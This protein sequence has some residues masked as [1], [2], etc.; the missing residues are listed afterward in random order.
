MIAI[1]GSRGE[2]G[3]QILRSALALSLITGVPFTI[4][5]IRA[6]R[7]RP[8]LQPQHLMCV[9]AAT[10]LGQ[11]QAIG[12]ALD[13]QR[14]EF[15]P[16]A[17]VGGHYEFP[18]RTA[19][20]SSLVLQTVLPP[21]LMAGEPSHV[22]VTG[23]TYN[24][25]APP[26]DFL[27]QT[28]L[29]QIRQLGPQVTLTL[30]RPGFYPRGGGRVAAEIQ[31]ARR[32]ARFELVE[33]GELKACRVRALV[34][35][36]DRPIAKRECQTVEKLSGLSAASCEIVELSARFGPGNVVLIELEFEQ[37]TEVIS[38]C[39]ERGLAAESVAERAWR[40]AERFQG[41]S[42]PVG[43]HLADQLLLPL[44]MGAA[45]CGTGGRFRTVPLSLH[46]TTNIELIQKFVAVQFEATPQEDG[47]VLVEIGPR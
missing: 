25:L 30:E 24:P 18:L 23:G 27:Q 9:T 19:G 13:S 22:S 15:R 34:A 36:L 42:A 46:T 44:A 38:A 26:T 33:R 43:E 41:L 17:V 11:A 32:L 4:S 47:T 5:R 37:I 31:P 35:G 14:L 12:A 28:F 40:E 16:G 8:G 1:D 20:S 2:G 6:T 29:P 45:L 10:R 7:K 3:G 21:L 39:G